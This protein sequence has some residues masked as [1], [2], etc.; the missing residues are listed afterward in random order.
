MF[1]SL[2]HHHFLSAGKTYTL[3]GTIC[4][5]SSRSPWPVPLI[6]SICR[7]RRTVLETNRCPHRC[8]FISSLLL[9]RSEG[10]RQIC[11]T[12]PFFEGFSSGSR[13][14]SCS[15]SSNLMRMFAYP[16]ALR[17]YLI[18]VSWTLR[19]LQ[20]CP[21]ELRM[22]VQDFRGCVRGCLEGQEQSG[23][24]HRGCKAD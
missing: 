6:P 22:P 17:Y 1:F 4:T 12:S 2:A 13:V 3:Q 11:C 7:T 16:P 24:P 18:V 9:G 20:F 15:I 19:S 10:L 8:R 23:W 14:P 5:T 21:S